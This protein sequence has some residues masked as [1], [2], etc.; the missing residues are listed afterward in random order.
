MGPVKTSQK[1]LLNSDLLKNMSAYSQFLLLLWVG[2]IASIAVS[3][4]ILRTYILRGGDVD[5]FVW[6]EHLCSVWGLGRKFLKAA[7]KFWHPK[8][9]D[10]LFTAFASS[11]KNNF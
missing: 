9:C 3:M 8:R 10:I 2:K 11:Q 6:L 1:Q 5:V 4:L 7:F